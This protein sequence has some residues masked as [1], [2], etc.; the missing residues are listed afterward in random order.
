MSTER[1]RF[2]TRVAGVAMAVCAAASHAAPDLGEPVTAAELAGLSIT[3]GPDGR[4][5]PPGRGTA[6]D[7]VDLYVEKCASCHGVRGQGRTGPALA[8]GAGSLTGR[9]PVRTVGSF[10]PHATTLFDYIRRAMPYDKPMSLTNEQVYQ[11]TA[12]VLWMN[13]I[14][15][16]DEAIDARSLPAVKMPNRAGFVNA[17]EARDRP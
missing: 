14:V 7:G 4:G 5:L 16:R 8:G 2:A 3:I 12:Y 1:S 11:L 6:I 17:W 13:G 9:A 15:G 10:W